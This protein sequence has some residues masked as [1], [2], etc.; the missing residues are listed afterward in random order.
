MSDKKPSEHLARETMNAT[1]AKVI[2][3]Q[4]PLAPLTN[5]YAQTLSNRLTR[6]LSEEGDEERAKEA[7]EKLR[8]QIR[9]RMAAVKK[10]KVTKDE[11]QSIIRPDILYNITKVFFNYNWSTSNGIGVSSAQPAANQSM[12]SVWA[13]DQSTTAAYVAAGV[14]I[15][16]SPPTGGSWTVTPK[17]HTYFNW[18]L[19]P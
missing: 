15:L 6:L 3:Q 4:R 5:E 2:E 14:G 19:W 7:S 12:V 17:V 11:P 10:P 13:E 1:A 16:F 9:K 18:N 8:A